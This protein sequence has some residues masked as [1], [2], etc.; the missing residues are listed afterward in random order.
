MF[1]DKEPV[2]DPADGGKSFL[3]PAGISASDSGRGHV[4][5]GDILLCANWLAS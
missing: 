4:V 1:F 3:L 5:L 2:K